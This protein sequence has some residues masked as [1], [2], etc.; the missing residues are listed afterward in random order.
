MLG[1]DYR[2]RKRPLSPN[3]FEKPLSKLALGSKAQCREVAQ[4]DPL[5]ALGAT[6]LVVLWVAAF[7]V[8]DRTI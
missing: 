8:A 2:T 3:V 6:R 5:L 4:Q 1:T 7:A